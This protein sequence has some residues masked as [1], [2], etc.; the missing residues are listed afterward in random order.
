MPTFEYRAKDGPVRAVDGVLDADSKSAVLAEL[1]AR[2]LTPVWVREKTPEKKGGLFLR[3]RVGFRDVTLFTSQLASL[4]KAGVPILRAM[5]TIAGQTENPRL[6]KVVNGLQRTI[7]DGNM[8]SVAL[9][10]YP[11]LFPELYINMIRAGESA[12]ILDS[13]LARLTE[14]REREED[15]RRKVQA[16]LAY[17]LLII[18]VGIATV[19]ALLAFFL[20]QVVEL[21]RDYKELP[22]PTRILMGVSDFF[23]HYWYWILFLAVLAGAVLN[24]IAALER[25]RTF[26][27]T[28][29]LHVPLL[30]RFI[31][32][33][34]ISRFARTLALLVEAGIPID[35]ALA[36]SAGTMR[37]AVLRGE[38][39]MIRKE[40]VEQGAT[41]SSG[42][43]RS[44]QFPALVTNMAAVG[45]EA[46]KLDEIMN[47]VA[48]FYEKQCDQRSRLAT[49][50]LEPILILIVGAVVGL[51]VAS[52]LLPIF[53]LGTGL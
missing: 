18:T 52:M 25:G 34:E 4:T 46:G 41:L 28:I 1:D 27:D 2:G 48:V 39:E 44:R 51:I 13:I 19:F 24:R 40:T 36:L 16:A 38:I 30:G 22:L 21:F 7:R 35:R 11:T 42:L 20:P 5:A 26:F 8:L 14:S 3:R 47:E 23:S 12:G 6:R 32:E 49:S 37:N 17:P 53:E 33:S 29:K 15:I 45:E 31:R 43:N 50:L 9:S 10:D